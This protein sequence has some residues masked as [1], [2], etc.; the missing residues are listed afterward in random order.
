MRFL[1]L[2]NFQSSLPSSPPERPNLERHP[3]DRYL[4]SDSPLGALG[5]CVANEMDPELNLARP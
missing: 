5:D 2:G 1:T 4:L 3:V